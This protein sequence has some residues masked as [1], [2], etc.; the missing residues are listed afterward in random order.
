MHWSFEVRIIE[1][2]TVAD[3]KGI[4]VVYCAVVQW[5]VLYVLF[6][7]Q[8]NGQHCLAK[9]ADN[10]KSSVCTLFRP[11]WPGIAWKNVLF[12]QRVDFW[13]RQ[14]QMINGRRFLF[15]DGH[16]ALQPKKVLKNYDWSI[17][18]SPNSQLSDSLIGTTVR[19]G[20]AWVWGVWVWV[21][22][23]GQVLDIE[24]LSSCRTA[25]PAVVYAQH[26]I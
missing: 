23:W 8:V 5:K 17:A 24:K 1:W 12:C 15:K 11:K 2:F 22:V 25:T 10:N 16:K 4:F 19:A 6:S 26:N 14:V 13:C 7:P 18:G 20:W 9:C 21:G 3:K